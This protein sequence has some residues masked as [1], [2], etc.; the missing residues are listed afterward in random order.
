MTRTISLV[1]IDLTIRGTALPPA[2]RLSVEVRLVQ[3]R[4]RGELDDV[5][6]ALTQNGVAGMLYEAS[7]MFLIH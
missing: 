4:S 2:I 1:A 5:F 6:M 7:S 3:V